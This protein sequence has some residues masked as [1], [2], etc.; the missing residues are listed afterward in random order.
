ML[1]NQDAHPGC[2]SSN[3]K[4]RR[5][6]DSLDT[7]SLGP[8]TK[9]SKT[10]SAPLP[11]RRDDSEETLEVHEIQAAS[12]LERALTETL[13]ARNGTHAVSIKEHAIIC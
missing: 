11:H 4:R 1:P 2:S 5:T 10:G 6:D 3:H 12:E 8:P 13:K 7:S 9:I